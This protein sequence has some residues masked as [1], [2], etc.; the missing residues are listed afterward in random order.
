MA[1]LS[2]SCVKDGLNEE[3]VLLKRESSLK[4]TVKSSSPVEGSIPLDAFVFRQDSGVLD[5]YVHSVDTDMDIAVVSGEPLEL[6][7]V[8]NAPEHSL[9]GLYKLEQF[10][11]ALAEF[12]DNDVGKF[13]M[14]SGNTSLILTQDTGMNVSLSRLASKVT[15]GSVRPSFVTP[16]L[17]ALGVSLDRAFL[18]NVTGKCH[19]DL[20]PSAG[21][22]RNCMEM[23][24]SLA[25]FERQS[26]CQDFH[27]VV[28]SPALIETDVSFHCFPNPVDNGVDSSTNPGWCPRNTRLVLQMTVAGVKN[29]YSI[30]MPAMECNKEYIIREVELKGYGTES[31]DLPLSRESVRFTV[32]VKQWEEKTIRTDV[33]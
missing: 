33:Y 3:T 20:T 16:E 22:W 10:H 6:D 25:G 29:Y 23:D 1:I 5:A 21:G 11:N 12:S 17:A 8:A 9:T 4:V 28:N 2:V 19:Y 15:L 26:Y 24:E 13:I 31:P 18:I 32:R 14:S 30:T 27:K 7:I